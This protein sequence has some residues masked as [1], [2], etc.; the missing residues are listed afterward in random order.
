MEALSFFFP[1]SELGLTLERDCSGW[2]EVLFGDAFVLDLLNDDGLDVHLDEVVIPLDVQLRHWRVRDVV[3]LDRD[4]LLLL[5][6]LRPRHLR[7]FSVAVRLPRRGAGLF[8]VEGGLGFLLVLMPEV[9][10]PIGLF[11]LHVEA[12]VLQRKRGKLSG[13][14][15]EE[16]YR[17]HVLTMLE[18]L[19]GSLE[20]VHG[21]GGAGPL[22][23][24]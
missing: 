2:V 24:G 5:L 22:Q 16:R 8:L 14:R 12:L 7:G 11:V 10:L 20:V 4:G 18:R 21:V 23:V 17:S 6:H 1:V 13:R 3:D 19:L 15:W 9:S